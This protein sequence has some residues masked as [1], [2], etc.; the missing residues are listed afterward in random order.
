MLEQMFA[1]TFTKELV[2]IV[3]YKND[4]TRTNKAILM[5]VLMSVLVTDTHTREDV[6]HAYQVEQSYRLFPGTGLLCL[7]R[8]TCQGEP[9]LGHT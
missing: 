7:Q 6:N 5:H 9:G 3:I 4:L 1:N 8:S 2:N